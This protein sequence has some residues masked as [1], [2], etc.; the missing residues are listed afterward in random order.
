MQAETGTRR[1]L[2]DL[3]E[4]SAYYA[5]SENRKTGG[6]PIRLPADQLGAGKIAIFVSYLPRFTAFATGLNR[7]R[8][9]MRAIPDDALRLPCS[10]TNNSLLRRGNLPLT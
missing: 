1:T 2:S 9:T 7:R 4:I 10:P 5:E 6:R 8:S 3:I